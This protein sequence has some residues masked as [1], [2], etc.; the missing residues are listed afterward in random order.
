MQGKAQSDRSAATRV[1][2]GIDVCKAWLD[3]HLHPLGQAFRVDNNGTSWKRLRQQLRA[4][5]VTLVVMEA[6]GKHHRAAHRALHDAGF[7]VAIV[8]PLRARLFAEAA[9]AL[10]KTDKID[11][12]ML[13][14]M[15]ESLEPRAMVPCPVLIESLQEL[16]RA[17]TAAVDHRTALSNQ[18]G[19]A[20]VALVQRELGRCMKHV[21]GH[22]DRLEK[23]IQR[24]IGSDPALA[25]RYQ[26]VLSIPGVGP[27]AA[28]WLVVGIAELGSCTGRQ[29]SMLAGLAPVDDRS[30][31]RDGV[32]RIRGGRGDVR[33]GIFMAALS[34]T[35]FNPDLKV[36]YERLVA[37]GKEHKKAIVAVMRKIVVLANTLLT[38][39]RHWQPLAPKIA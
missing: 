2:V 30:G 9:G 25:H 24:L 22:I 10:A 32:K 33:R 31:S 34:A 6:T 39:Q 19:E 3:V 37:A 14:L 28:A 18:L 17:R 20:R 4:C 1:Y 21:D 13:A 26:I 11:A 35:R 8:N 15:G 16:M 29:A 38:E 5:N 36:V 12:R 27:S 23:E 7:A